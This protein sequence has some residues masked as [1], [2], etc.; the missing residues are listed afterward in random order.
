MALLTDFMLELICTGFVPDTHIYSENC[1]WVS[2]KASVLFNIISFSFRIKN[3]SKALVSVLPDWWTTFNM[4][5][6]V[7]SSLERF[8]AC[9]RY[10]PYC[11]CMSVFKPTEP[12][13]GSGFT[14]PSDKHSTAAGCDPSCTQLWDVH[15]GCAHVFPYVLQL[16]LLGSSAHEAE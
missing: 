4:R 15:H 8:L 10:R 1:F 7:P 16:S 2:L 12:S 9:S 6:L 13:A 5:R 14:G 11:S 3:R